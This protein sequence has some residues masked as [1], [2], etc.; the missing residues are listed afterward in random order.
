MRPLKCFAGILE[1]LKRFG[2]YFADGRRIGDHSRPTGLCGWDRLCFYLYQLLEYST[3]K[4]SNGTEHRAVSLRH[5]SSVLLLLLSISQGVMTVCIGKVFGGPRR[6]LPLPITSSSS[7]TRVS[8]TARLAVVLLEVDAARQQP[9]WA[10][11][12]RLVGW[13]PGARRHVLVPAARRRCG[14]GV[15]RHVRR[16]AVHDRRSRLRRPAR[17]RLRHHRVRRRGKGGVRQD[18][19]R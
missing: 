6:A 16:P 12:R 2:W 10:G 7:V 4:T 19:F 1:R 18:G 11:L 13:S 17:S 15:F 5:L 9:T 14:L 8:A 3:R